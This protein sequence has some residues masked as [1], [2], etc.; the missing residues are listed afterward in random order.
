[1]RTLSTC[2]SFI[3]S[4]KF[5]LII[6]MA[7]LFTFSATAQLTGQLPVNLKTFKA[8]AENNNKIKIFWTTE[9]EKDNAYFDIERSADGV[10]FTS[11]GKV[12]GVNYN[13]RLTDYIFYDPHPIK[14]ISY[15][16][17]KQV[18]VD[19]KFNYSPIERVK[20]SDTDNSFDIF[21]NPPTGHEFKIDLLKNVPGNIDVAVFDAGGSLRLQ[22]QYGTNGIITVI[23]NLPAGIYTVKITG[24]EFG[25]SKMLV[26]Q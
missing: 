20:I 16:R 10:N 18:D 23:H 13:G 2:K 1:M 21:P 8:V 25:A 6:F 22:Q 11:A 4:L 26:I 15:Y 19:G 12:P 24:K 9:Y 7:M 17:L 3:A 5:V 14:G